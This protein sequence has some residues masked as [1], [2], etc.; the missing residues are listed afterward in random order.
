MSNNCH[1]TLVIKGKNSE[2]L[3]F[4]AMLENFPMKYELHCSSTKDGHEAFFITPWA[5]PVKEVHALQ[6]L[7]PDL[8]IE[9]HFDEAL[10]ELHGV[11]LS[12]GN[13]HEDVVYVDCNRGSHDCGYR[14]W[15]GTGKR[16]LKDKSNEPSKLLKLK[17]HI[18]SR[19]RKAK[20]AIWEF[21][22]RNHKDDSF[23]VPF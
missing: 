23:D 11:V 2:K 16:L 22:F 7:F 12:S 5:P 8:D 10:T 9:L 15:D 18:V 20:H 21:R 3:C 17:D 14:V 4:E 13:L 1:N 6:R 19:Y